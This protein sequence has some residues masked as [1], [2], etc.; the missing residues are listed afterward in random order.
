MLMLMASTFVYTLILTFFT[1]L[2]N[3]AEN[4]TVTSLPFGDA[5]FTFFIGL[6]KGLADMMPWL[7]V[8]LTLIILALTLK[9]IFIS[10]GIGV[11]V[12]TFIRG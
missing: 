9:V 7:Q 1:F 2:W 12:L 3:G 4:A 11:R 10:I 8:P 5:E 6:V